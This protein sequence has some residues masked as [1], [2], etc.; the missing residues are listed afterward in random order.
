MMLGI[1]WTYAKKIVNF[2]WETNGALSGTKPAGE[3]ASLAVH[4]RKPKKTEEKP[5]RV[6]PQTSW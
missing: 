4:H 1:I 2:M 5:R 6:E 3:I